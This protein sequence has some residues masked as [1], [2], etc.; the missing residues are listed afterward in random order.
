MTK[1]LTIAGIDIKPGDHQKIELPMSKLYTDTGL[2]MPVSVWR[3]KKDGPT[4]LICAAMHGDELNGIEIVSRIMNSKLLQ[5]LRGTLIAVP[6]IN[7]YGV[8]NL[9]RYLPD[10]RDLN[11]SFPGSKRGSLA[12]RMAYRFLNEIVVKCDYG[13]DLHTGGQHRSNLPQIRANLTETAA[14][15]MAHA[16]GV[17]VLLNSN[18]RDGSL[19]QAADELGIPMILYEGGQSLR[20]DEVPI[21]V[22]VNGVIRVMRHLGMIPK[23]KSSKTQIKSHTALSSTWIRASESGIVRVKCDLGDSVEKDDVLAE[24]RTPFGKVI[25]TVRCNQS[26]V[27]I[28]KQNIPLIQEGEAMF[29]VAHF[30]EPDTVIE[31]L[32]VQ[33]ENLIPEG[34]ATNIYTG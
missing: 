31:N 24:I 9:S 16:F 3:G 18:L 34:P 13:I 19:R 2:N 4:L 25:G 7:S 8:I 15:E 26:G 32:E 23:L 14:S 29:H 22:G 5:R 28:G 10:G 11:R 33:L 20:F 21:R 17:P 12:S 30:V 27:I 1:T 6:I